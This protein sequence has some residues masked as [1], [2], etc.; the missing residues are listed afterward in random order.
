MLLHCA[1]KKKQLYRL[2]CHKSLLPS[3]VVPDSSKSSLLLYKYITKAE[4]LLTG[5][6]NYLPSYLVF[7][8]IAEPTGFTFIHRMPQVVCKTE[9]LFILLVVCCSKKR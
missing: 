4:K 5:K 2:F 8:Q 7:F 3:T 6:M 9:Q 1:P